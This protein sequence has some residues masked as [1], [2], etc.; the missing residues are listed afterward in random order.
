M[1]G[2]HLTPELLEASYEYLRLS[3]PF[4][5]WNLPEG[6]QISFRVM[7]A[8]DRYGH[9]R[10]RHT[11]ARAKAR[12]S[13]RGVDSFSE[14]AISAGKVRSTDMLM[15][16]M[17]HEMIHLYQDETG[18]ARGHHNPQFLSLA[19]RVCAFHGFDLESF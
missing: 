12:A 17:A 6:D 14:I 16:T 9:F 13:A 18:S 8:R 3:P 11:K 10:G 7:G 15:A 2:L 19:A 1:R 5:G 4:R